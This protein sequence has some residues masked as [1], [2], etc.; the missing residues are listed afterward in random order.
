MLRADIRTEE[1]R[2]SSHLTD[3]VTTRVVVVGAGRVGLPIAL[4]FCAAGCPVAILETEPRRVQSLRRG[5]LPF[6]EIGLEEQ[7]QTALASGALTI[8]ADT[9]L[10]SEAD[11]IIVTVGTPLLPGLEAD[12]SHVRRAA[13]SIGPRLQSHTLV[14]WRSTLPPGGTRMAAEWLRRSSRGR[15]DISIANAYCP[16]RLAEGRAVMELG[17]LPQV[18]GADDREAMEQATSLFNMVS[19]KTAATSII[20]AELGKIFSNAAR[21]AEFAIGNH[22]ALSA[23][24]LGGD[25]HEI[26]RVFTD[27][28]PR[29]MGALPGF[30]GGPCLRKDFA[31]VGER[32]FGP[33][34]L[35]AAWRVHETTPARLIG[36]MRRRQRLE[37]ARVAILGLS[38]KADV[39]DLRDSLSTRLFRELEREFVDEIRASDPYQPETITIEGVGEVRNWSTRDAIVDAD[40][41]IVAVNHSSY[42]RE[43][44]HDRL[45]NGSLIVD[46]WNVTG[47]GKLFWRE[48]RRGETS[49]TASSE[50]FA[51]VLRSLLRP[52]EST[53]PSG[54]PEW[55][56]ADLVWDLG[57]DSLAVMEMI[58]DLEV[59]FDIAIDDESITREAI[60]SPSSLWA[61]VRS[62]IQ[63]CRID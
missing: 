56:E 49:M 58:S 29:G 34:L 16:E 57:M 25:Y 27:D 45:E 40:V 43:L 18:I 52:M 13:E 36:G 55:W 28:Y 1:H 14:V 37:G 63:D 35:T 42:H 51:H 46:I 6:Q 10:V 19:P 26:R 11:A 4:A 22:L 24:E 12:L 20:N 8:S 21:Y 53:P 38:F 9:A 44:Y 3:C 31:L 50:R 39:D 54:T 41:V 62:H 15:P 5:A 48:D 23:D 32:S 7:L 2:L 30:T 33:D 61:L 47:K 59:E 60:R 17:S